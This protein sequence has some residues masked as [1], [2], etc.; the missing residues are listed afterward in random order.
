MKPETRFTRKAQ[1]ASLVGLVVLLAVVFFSFRACQ[2]R[3]SNITSTREN[4]GTIIRSVVPV[5]SYAEVVER[6]SPAVVTIRSERRV[7]APQQH[8]FLDDPFFR[9]FFGD[10]FGPGAPQQRER[11][12]RGLGSG[13]IV[14]EDGYILTNHH[15]IDGAEEIKVETIENKVFDATVVGTDP[16]SDLAVLKVNASGLPV[17]ALGDSDRVRTGDVVLAVGNPL[18]VG[19]TVTAGIISAKGRS[20]GLSDGSFEDFLQT[21]APINQGNSGGALVSTN[22]EMIGVN[23]QILSPTGGNIGIGFAIPSNMAR[24][25]MEQLIK[26]GNVRRGQLGVTVQQV[27]SEIAQ[28]LGLSEARGVI[29]NS[30]VPGSAAE[31]AGIRRGDILVSIN[32]E[33]IDSPNTLRN[34]IA[35]KAPGTEVSLTI[36]RDG[37]EQEV[38]AS[39]GELTANTSRPNPQQQDQGPTRGRLGVSVQPLTPDLASQLGLDS[40]TQG[41]VVTSVEPSSPA[42]ES[43]IR[44]GDVIAE[45]NRQPVRSV[46]ELQ[47]AV[48]QAGGRPLL[49]LINRRGQ[50]AFIAVRPR[51]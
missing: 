35:S 20:T 50:T 18:G 29:V 32:G 37:R 44:Q 4:G 14:S 49:L 39:L 5:D 15:V 2:T 34:S 19:Q 51:G 24:N 27:T 13:V 30:V 8:P 16:P 6:V 7:R 1:I 21:D 45:A 17:L 47:A 12:Q 33:Q 9:D 38:R 43:G 36:L 25:V 22:G 48:D 42:A 26:S 28:S 41:L 11:V 23:S 3:D 10:R 40:N 46:E 31:R